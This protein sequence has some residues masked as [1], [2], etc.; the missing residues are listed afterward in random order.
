MRKAIVFLVLLMF[1]AFAQEKIFGYERIDEPLEAAVTAYIGREVWAY[2]RMSIYCQNEADTPE[3]IRFYYTTPELRLTIDRIVTIKNGDN[4]W[5]QVQTIH[6]NGGFTQP[7]DYSGLD[8]E[9]AFLIVLRTE[10]P[11][12]ND[13]AAFYGTTPVEEELCQDFF[14]VVFPKAA[15]LERIFSFESIHDVA[16]EKGW[17]KKILPKIFDLYTSVQPGM[18]KEMVLWKLGAPLRPLELKEALEVAYWSYLSWVPFSKDVTF[19][20]KDGRVIKYIEGR[21]P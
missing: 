20:K 2:G 5:Q 1:P 3:S 21:L 6:V 17:P 9:I 12:K 7:G 4:I 16:K 18:T 15:Y 14:T 19:D 13:G 10:T 8:S 11:I